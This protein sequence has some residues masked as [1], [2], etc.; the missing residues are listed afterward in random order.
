MLV[1]MSGAACEIGVEDGVLRAAE[2]EQVGDIDALRRSLADRC[3]AVLQQAHEQARALVEDAQRRAAA[4]TEAAQADARLAVTQGYEAGMRRAILEWH[5]KQAAQSVDKATALRRMHEKLAAIVTAS[6]ERI[7]HSEQREALYQRA[8]RS[9]QG[10]ARGATSLALRVSAV[11]HEHARA[12]LAS[13]SSLA[14]LGLS[15]EMSVDPSL[16]PGSCVFETESG[17]VDASL[18]TQLEGLRTAMDRAVSKAVAEG[19]LDAASAAEP[20]AAQD[21][22]GPGVRESAHDGDSADDHDEVEVEDDE[23]FEGGDRG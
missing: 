7:V 6:V 4:L 14:E 17:I 2:V 9:V 3:D 5:E 18:H 10:M 23:A 8:L 11:D 19:E 12:A 20:S 16:P 22:V 1:W 15:V 13:L 21:V